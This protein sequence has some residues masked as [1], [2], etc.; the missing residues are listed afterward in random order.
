MKQSIGSGRGSVYNIILKALQSGDKYGYEICQEI[1]TKTNGNYILKQPSLYSG[2]KRLESQKLVTSY[3]GD[4]EIGGRRHYYSLTQEGKQKIEQSNFSWED[5]R[6]DIVENFFQKTES[7]KDAEQIQSEIDS[8]SQSVEQ[9]KEQNNQLSKVL[10]NSQN[11]FAH[12]ICDDQFDLFSYAGLSKEIENEKIAPN[13][14]K[15]TQQEVNNT[16]ETTNTVSNKQDNAKNDLLNEQSV[17]TVDFDKVFSQNTVASFSNHVEE[18]VST[19]I[20][21]NDLE[22]STTFYGSNT[23]YD[24]NAVIDDDFDKKYEQFSKMFSDD[25]SEQVPT[26]T[27][28]QLINNLDLN[29]ESYNQ[30]QRLL[31]EKRMSDALS[32][33]LNS[34]QND[35]PLEKTEQNINKNESAKSDNLIQS[36]Q[37][38]LENENL[39]SEQ[40]QLNLKSIFDGVILDEKESAFYDSNVHY[41]DYENFNDA[42]FGGN[43]IKDIKINQDATLQQENNSTDDLP[44]YDLTD[45]V[46][47]SL[48]TDKQPHKQYFNNQLDDNLANDEYISQNYDTSSAPFDQKAQQNNVNQNKPLM[49]NNYHIRY[50]RKNNIDLS[51]SN[52]I[53][54]NKL[55]FGVMLLICLTGLAVTLGLFFGISA[56]TKISPIQNACYIINIVIFVTILFYYLVMFLKDKN[57]KTTY[58]FDKNKFKLRLFL[59]ILIIL[60]IIG[61]NVLMGLTTK[62]IISFVPTLILPII[63]MILFVLAPIF[64]KIFNKFPHYAK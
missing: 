20:S 46:N 18:V 41:K 43:D 59:S 11:K 8:L 2:L 56:N 16:N 13:E 1:E 42:N 52:Y 51:P 39:T 55:N 60:T 22:K 38:M 23:N 7:Q 45:N 27:Q 63:D 37:K 5:E 32:G 19:P 54:I 40:T 48:Y 25:Q 61:A 36:P 49:T 44:R 62:N 53:A 34:A 47:L 33:T 12:K 9:V 28:E 21:L 15:N 31:Q 29:N 57:Y 26:L 3:W 17:Q 50:L 4:S 35:L 10:S 64:K 24:E 14:S 6:N 58:N 30:E